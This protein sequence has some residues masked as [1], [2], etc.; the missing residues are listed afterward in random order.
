MKRLVV[1]IAAAVMC[2]N[3][4]ACQLLTSGD[5]ENLDFHENAAYDSEMLDEDN[6]FFIF[7]WLT[8]MEAAVTG[9]TQSREAYSEY[10]GTYFENMKSLGVTD[11]FF[12]VR[13][14]G[15]AMYKSE[16]Y[17]ESRYVSGADFDVL[18]CACTVAEKN[19]INL[20]AWINPYRLSADSDEKNIIITPSGKYLNPASDSVKTKILSGA[21]ELM[22][23]YNL[24]GIH[25]DDYFYP[26][27]MDSA[28]EEQFQSYRKKGGTLSLAQWRREN[29]ST[30]LQSLYITVKAYGKDKLFSVS[31]TGNIDKNIN[32][33]Y[34]DVERWC[35]DEGYCDIILPQ[36]Y[37]GFLNESQPFE[38][39]LDRWTELCRDS[40]VGLVP[41]LALYKAGQTDKFAG[42]EGR[43]EWVNNSDVLK[44]QI[45]I[46]KAEKLNGVALYSASYINFSK[47]FL[48]RELNNIKSVI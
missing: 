8:Y 47:T 2:F 33:L 25:I 5:S 35:S 18:E 45:D 31:P 43:D 14:F 3:F 40:S 11:C 13:P 1:L 16:I 6:D 28:D 23:N 15:D 34:A 26:P 30:L 9:E 39:C 32:Q 44:R 10:I 4:S 38:K 46:I 36:I 24:K 7:T 20:H 22:E 27:D 17:P 12:Q 42:D 48:S 37:F 21:R 29:V 19:G 41:A